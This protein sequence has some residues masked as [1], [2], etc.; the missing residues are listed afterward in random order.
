MI[1]TAAIMRFAAPILVPA[2]EFRAIW[3]DLMAADLTRPRVA[4]SLAWLL[5]AGLVRIIA[6]RAVFP[7]GDFGG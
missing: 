6:D 7:E 3:R 1:R 2:D 4:R 5:K